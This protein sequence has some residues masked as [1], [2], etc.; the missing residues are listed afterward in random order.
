MTWTPGDRIRLETDRFVLDSVTREDVDDEFLSWMADPEV[1]LGLNMPPRR[2]SRGQSVH[3]A[4]SFDNLSKSMLIVRDRSNGQKIG[5][6]TISFRPVHQV[7]ETAVVIGNKEYWGKNVVV[8]ARG[9]ILKFL[10]EEV[11]VHKVVGLPHGRNMSSIF[12]YQAMG[13][14]CEAVLREQMASVNGE[15]RLDQLMFGLLRSEWEAKQGNGGK[16]A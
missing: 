11:G 14:T 2:M 1:M 15:E 13:F 9:A 8:E 3:Y 6:F 12:N 7:A 10:F 4:M 5:M 16:K